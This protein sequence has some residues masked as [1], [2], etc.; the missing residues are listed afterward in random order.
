MTATKAL[1][2]YGNAVGVVTP[3]D[4]K[5]AQ[6]G[7][8]AKTALNAVRPGLFWGGNASVIV[9]KANM[10]YDVI[11]FTAALS[12]GATSG[13]VLLSNDG[14]LNVATTAAPGSNSR[15]DIIYVWAREYSLDGVDSNPVIGVAQ[16]TAAASPTAP[17]LASFPG[18]IEIGRATVGAGITATTSAT[19][20]Q[21]APFTAMDGGRIPFRNTTERDA[22]TYVEGQLGWLIDTNILQV[23]SGSAWANVSDD[24]TDT[25]W[26]ALPMSNSWVDFNAAGGTYQVLQYRKHNGMTEVRGLIKNGTIAAG[27]VIATLPAGFRPLKQRVMGAV[28]NFV[29]GSVEVKANGEIIAG[30]VSSNSSLGIELTFAAEQ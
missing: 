15:I 9:G 12:R 28:A 29:S 19:I 30:T 25:A 23:Y 3:A 2:T 27:T 17:S 8:I 21:T 1:G 18:A 24:P 6:S 14:T 7:L 20:T 22:G 13:T 5:A 11:A 26:A 16:G 4:H 10:S